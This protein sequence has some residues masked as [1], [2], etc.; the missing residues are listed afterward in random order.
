M[1]NFALYMFFPEWIFLIETDREKLPASPRGNTGEL[2]FHASEMDIIRLLGIIL[3]SKTD[4]G[5]YMERVNLVHNKGPAV[6][7][8]ERM[9]LETIFI[10]AGDNLT[11]KQAEDLKMTA[12]LKSIY[13]EGFEDGKRKG[14]EMAALMR[15]KAG[16]SVELL[17][18]ILPLP[19]ERLRELEAQARFGGGT[20]TEAS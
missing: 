19:E 15:L 1:Y 5:L 6:S 8:L 12:R 9:F 2:E 7:E 20:D 16:Y 10:V 18:T 4:F 14:M 13:D 17:K 11:K 3:N